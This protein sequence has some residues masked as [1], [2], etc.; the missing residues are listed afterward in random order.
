VRLRFVRELSPARFAEIGKL[1]GG[2]KRADAKVVALAS[3]IDLLCSPR[4]A[5]P[6]VV[7]GRGALAAARGGER[8]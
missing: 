2:W 1:A 3:E 7:G 5:R 8:Q 4:P 6:R